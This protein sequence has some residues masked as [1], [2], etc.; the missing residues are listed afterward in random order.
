VY[1]KHLKDCSEFV[2]GDNSLLREILNP[3]KENIPIHYSLA[4]AMVKP[5]E[6]TLPHALKST[7]VYYVVNGT[8]RMHINNEKRLVKLNDTVYIPPNAVQYIENTGNENLE[9]LCIVDP[10][11]QPETET[12]LKDGR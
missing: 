5:G 7:E 2:A 11:W 3:K 9:F 8:G 10:A 4:W 6:K 1:F 12:I